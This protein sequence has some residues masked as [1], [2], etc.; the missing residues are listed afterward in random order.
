MKGKENLLHFFGKGQQMPHHHGKRNQQIQHC[1]G[2]S[3]ETKSMP[4][5]Y[6]WGRA[7]PTT[8]QHI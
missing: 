2:E 1:R 6:M 3:K 7:E 4:T 5:S 8:D